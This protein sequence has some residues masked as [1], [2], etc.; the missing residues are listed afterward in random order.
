MTDY[1]RIE[2]FEGWRELHPDCLPEPQK[3]EY[4][5]TVKIM[6]IL[7]YHLEHAEARAYDATLRSVIR[8][9]TPAPCADNHPE[10]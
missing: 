4:H 6:M 5:E 1:E 7:G 9:P 2:L 8:P 10:I 3:A